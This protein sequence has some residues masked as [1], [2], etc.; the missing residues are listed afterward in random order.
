MRSMR[1]SGF[2]VASGG[3]GRAR[4]SSVRA[5]VGLGA[6]LLG[7]GHL[8]CSNLDNGPVICSRPATVEPLLY[9]GG[10]VEDG[11]YTSGDWAGEL[12]SFGGGAY[13]Q[14]Q[15]HLGERPR[16]LQFFLSFDRDGIASGGSLSQAAG[17]E[18]EVMGLSEESVTVMNGTCSDFWLLAVIGVGDA[19]PTP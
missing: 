1:R 19:V 12:L 4:S 14:I 17:N 6:L 3:R 15:H 5:A 9:D 18:V 7:G 16:V 11:W 8:G 2:A 13:Y 10:T